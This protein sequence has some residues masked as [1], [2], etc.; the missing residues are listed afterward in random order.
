MD[1]LFCVLFFSNEWRG[2]NGFLGG[3]GWDDNVVWWTV[4]SGCDM[5][6]TAFF[7]MSRVSWSCSHVIFNVCVCG[8]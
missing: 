8:S 3:M 6:G 1:D 5:I 2:S 7:G 4:L